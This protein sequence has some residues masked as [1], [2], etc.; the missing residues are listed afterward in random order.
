MSDLIEFQYANGN[1]IKVSQDRLKKHKIEPFSNIVTNK[2]TGIALGIDENDNFYYHNDKTNDISKI[3]ALEFLLEDFPK[4][5]EIQIPS[6][7]ILQLN[8][9]SK[10]DEL[11]MQ[12][13]SM[14]RKSESLEWYPSQNKDGMIMLKAK[15]SQ[16]IFYV[17]IGLSTFFQNL[18]KKILMD[19]ERK[20][21]IDCQETTLEW[22]IK[23]VYNTSQLF[24]ED[25]P[26]NEEY[27]K[28]KSFFIKYPKL[29]DT[30]YRIMNSIKIIKNGEK[31]DEKQKNIM[32]EIDNIIEP[33][34]GWVFRKFYETKYFEDQDLRLL[35]PEVSQKEGIIIYFLMRE[36]RNIYIQ[37]EETLRKSLLSNNL[38]SSREIVGKIMNLKPK[39][40]TPIWILEALTQQI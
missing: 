14:K 22:F 30:Y 3:G 32:K 11:E 23:S 21:E 4:Q 28:V 15:D 24:I 38:P 6:I 26:S 1:V 20:F 40:T 39:A 27:E 5:K 34:K 2:G 16:K 13:Q 37:E 18:K 10:K 17:H 7:N 12:N 35:I 9:G 25:L 29:V 36:T 8:E 31:L 33:E 19:G